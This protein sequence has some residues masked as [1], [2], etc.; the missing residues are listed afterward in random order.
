MSNSIFDVKDFGAL[1]DGT[2]D[3]YPAFQRA[4]D[5]ITALASDTDPRGAVLHIPFGIFKL[6][7]TLHLRRQMII[8]GVSGSGDYAG[9]RLH[10]PDGID[11]VVIERGVASTT[12]TTSTTL[13]A[14]TINVASTSGFAG[15]G[16]LVIGANTVAYTGVTATSFT[17]CSGGS[18][19]F[20]AGTIV[21]DGTA[22]S[23]RVLG[24]WTII[25]DLGLTSDNQ[26]VFDKRQIPA[27]NEY[28]P[29]SAT[30]PH[31]G[32]APL[33]GHGIVLN[34]RARIVNCSVSGF[35][36]DGI[37]IDTVD[38]YKNANNFE[39]QNCRVTSNGRH[40]L[41]VAS[42]PMGA[43]A[44]RIFGVDFSNNMGWGVYDR[45]QLGN[46]YVGVHCAENG[47]FAVDMRA[48]VV[49]ANNSDVT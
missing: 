45:S 22:A 39:I 41:Y 43:Q 6:S 35:R 36:C 5:A 46:T 42:G 29:L 47:H 10:F 24:D 8:R 32:H 14:G 49:D 28:D 25:T 40:G 33:F 11:G 13:P 1:G 15:S 27:F 16:A 31:T 38:S 44:G 19:I 37:H 34:S 20:P 4:L 26:H 21:Q 48:V 3:D 30:Q 23:S 18:D 9:S 12:L 17:G 7:K 2:T